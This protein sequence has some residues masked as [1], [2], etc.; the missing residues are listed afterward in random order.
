MSSRVIT[1]VL[2]ALVLGGATP[3]SQAAQI[4]RKGNGPEPKTLDPSRSEGIPAANILRDLFQGLTEEQPDGRI[5]PGVAARWDISDDGR[6]Y[7]FFLRDNARWSNGD[8]VVSEDFVFSL[9][10]SVDP[11]TGSHYASMLLPIRNAA[12]V[13]EGR[14]PPERLGVSAITPQQLRIELENATPY[15]LGQLT[16]A[17]AYPVHPASVT[18]LGERFARPG[19]LISNGAYRLGEWTV[20]SHVLLERNPYYWDDAHTAIDLVYHYNTE[21]LSSELKRYRAGELDWTETIPSSQGDWIR[22]ELG[23]ELK[24]HAYLGSYYYGFNLSRPPFKDQPGLRK[25]LALAIDRE[26]IVRKVLGNGELPAYAWVPPGIPGYES[27]L[28]EWASASREQRVQEARRLYAAAGYS[29]RKPLEV[30]IR[31]NTSEDHKRV[32]LAIAAMWKQFLGVKTRLVNEEWKVFLQTRRSKAVTQVFRAAWIGDYNDPHSFLGLLTSSNGMNDTGYANP[33]YDA[34]I[35]AAS[36]DTDPG[37]RA[38]TLQQA[39]AL[40]L[41]DLPVLPIYFYVSKHLV[42]PWVVGWQGNVMDHHHTK[43]MRLLPH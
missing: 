23:D 3:P 17:T 30:E 36:A 2:L 7:T 18:A 4:L 39:E 25:A 29:A 31:Y 38:A 32:A 5:G 20:Q 42:K 43:D 27:V 22:A 13:I 1:V 33:R 19:N 11:A 16:H 34:L 14:L 37:H 6:V 28:P 10:R 41:D 35:A 8:A 26:V 40:V 15:F 12:A 24:I 21:D 9:R